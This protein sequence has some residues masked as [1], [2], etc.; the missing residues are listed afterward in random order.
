MKR[1]FFLLSLGLLS[2]SLLTPV[3][4]AQD[5]GDQGAAPPA[6]GHQMEGGEPEGGGPPD[7]APPP[8]DTDKLKKRLG[9]SDEQAAKFKDALKAHQD[10]VKPVQEKLRDGMKKLM[11]Q[12]KDK[13]DDKEI[14]AT[15]DD[16]ESAHKA[17]EEENHKFAASTAGYLTPTQR[18]KML[19]GMMMRM[20]QGGRQGRGGGHRGRGGQGDGDGGGQEGG[21]PAQGGGDSNQ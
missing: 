9:L 4:R 3:L 17:M 5:D 8:M 18:A 10:A 16:L 1:T 7:G 14:A 15:L 11:G 19:V 6:G 21:P 20:R 13:A 12:L 2:G